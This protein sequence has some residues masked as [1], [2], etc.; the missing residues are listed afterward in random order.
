MAHYAILDENNIV[1]QVIV[2]K[3][4]NER[5][6]GEPM[7]WE[8]YYG[9]KRTSYNTLGG[10]YYHP[11]TGE[12]GD[13]TKAFRKNFAG[14]GYTYDEGRDAFIAPKPYPSWL[15]D[16]E[17]CQWV[18][19]VPHPNDDKTYQWDEDSLTWDQIV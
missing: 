14:I 2:G 16:E 10:V 6:N 11:V 9:G 18:P 1:T 19:P 4:G 3:D 17:S 12:P 15:L 5:W 13:Q 8:A 7:D